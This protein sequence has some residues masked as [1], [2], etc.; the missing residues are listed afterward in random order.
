MVVGGVVDV[1]ETLGCGTV[2]G[3][4][5]VDDWPVDICVTVGDW[6]VDGVGIV[7]GWTVDG[8][9]TVSDWAVD[10]CGAVCVPVCGASAGGTVV[11]ADMK[12]VVFIWIKTKLV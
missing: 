11:W 9:G 5:I 1:G 8:C 6:A 2:D 7:D 4:G 3:D 12:K 10:G